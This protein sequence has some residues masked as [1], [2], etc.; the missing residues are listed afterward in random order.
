MFAVSSRCRACGNS[1]D[2]AA[3][4]PYLC[5]A[6]QRGAGAMM[7]GVLGL[8]MGF[9]P[10]GGVLPRRRAPLPGVPGPIA[11][12][13]AAHGAIVACALCGDP[14]HISANHKCGNCGGYGHRAS[15]CGQFPIGGVQC[16]V[17]GEWDHASRE[18][19][20]RNCGGNGHKTSMCSYVTM[21][22]E[23]SRSGCSMRVVT[24]GQ[25]RW[26]VR[27]ICG[28]RVGPNMCTRHHG[29]AGAC[30]HV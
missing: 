16:G 23:R 4:P 2:A 3:S 6:C 11:A 28:Q 9:A 15:A 17:C 8:G 10:A 13:A 22:R 25:S 24:D 26:C 30:A 18:H 21:C 27:H 5:S 1:S 7:V 20:C 29:H 14:S 19:N 12:A